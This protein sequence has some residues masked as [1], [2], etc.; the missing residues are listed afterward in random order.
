MIDLS[1]LHLIVLAAIRGFSKIGT[2]RI[3]FRSTENDRPAIA[4]N[5]TSIVHTARA[6][7]PTAQEAAR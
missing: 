1:A 7:D 6:F 5:V 3:I 2:D 4:G